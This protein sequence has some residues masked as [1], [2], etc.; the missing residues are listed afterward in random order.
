VPDPNWFAQRFRSAEQSAVQRPRSGPL[1]EHT[2]PL[3]HAAVGE[4]RSPTAPTPPPPLEDVLPPEDELPPEDPPPEDPPPEDPPPEEPPSTE[5][6]PEP[7]ELLEHAGIPR[8]KAGR[9]T[10]ASVADREGRSMA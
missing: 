4:H 8:L 2:R 6:V 3:A 7:E 1:V 10:N 9:M 5:L